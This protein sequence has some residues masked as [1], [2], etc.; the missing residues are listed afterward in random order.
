MVLSRASSRTSA[1]SPL[2]PSRMGRLTA[3]GV[4]LACLLLLPA[5]GWSAPPGP[6]RKQARKPSPVQKAVAP[7]RTPAAAPNLRSLLT[8]VDEA[9]RARFHFTNL[10]DTTP[11][12]KGAQGTVPTVASLYLSLPGGL[13]KGS[14]ET[15][16]WPPFRGWTGDGQVDLTQESVRARSQFRGSVPLEG[17][18]LDATLT[19]ERK[20]GNL[21]LGGR[22]RLDVP[23]QVRFLSLARLTV[24]GSSKGTWREADNSLHVSVSVKPDVLDRRIPRRVELRLAHTDAGLTF[25]ATVV[26]PRGSWPGD[27]NQAGHGRPGPSGGHGTQAGPGS[28]DFPGRLPRGEGAGRG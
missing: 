23:T 18:T 7:P 20:A 22:L 8:L 10:V 24:T 19:Q 17:T 6:A 27:A 4:A 25:R 2:L 28:E 13:L 1:V 15:G 14:L 11:L 26:A 3:C 9:G 21:D 16:G 5:G 12:Q